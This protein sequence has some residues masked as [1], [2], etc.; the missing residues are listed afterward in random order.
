MMPFEGRIHVL[1]LDPD[2]CSRSEALQRLVSWP[3]A[4][5]RDIKRKAELCHGFTQPTGLAPRALS[6]SAKDNNTTTIRHWGNPF[7]NRDSSG[8]TVQKSKIIR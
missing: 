4:T 1:K 7:Q 2:G 8:N 5:V 6:R 3:T